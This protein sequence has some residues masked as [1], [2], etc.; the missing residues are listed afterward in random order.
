[1]DAECCD[2]TWSATASD[3]P[4]R[5]S[6]D[7][8]PVAG[9]DESSPVE[10]MRALPLGA[11]R[12]ENCETRVAHGVGGTEMLLQ[13]AAVERAHPVE[14]RLIFDR[15]E[16]HDDGANSSDLKGAAQTKHTFAHSDFPEARVARR[17][18]RPLD[19][20]QIQAG[21]LFS[22]ENAVLVV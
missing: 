12:A 2:R 22:G 14:R 17:E 18:H 4:R 9:G 19:A 7:S 6:T 10:R 21:D 5:A 20:F 16:A 3:R 1:M 13:P 11:A 8:A 15:P